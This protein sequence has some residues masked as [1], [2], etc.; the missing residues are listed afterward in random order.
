M[1]TAITI[2][3]PLPNVAQ[4]TCDFLR[5]KR[6]GE[7]SARDAARLADILRDEAALEL[8]AAFEG[9]SH[10]RMKAAAFPGVS[11]TGI[12]R[13]MNGDPSNPLSRLAAAFLLMRR[14]GI[15]R[16]RA[17]KLWLWL[18]EV[19]DQIW[20]PEEAEDEEGPHDPRA[21]LEAVR[22]IHAF[23]PRVIGTLRRL[24]AAEAIR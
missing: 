2:G 24:V 15:D 3:A 7:L 18:R 21:A 9:V 16:K 6:A 10:K 4:K 22:I 1:T 5:R 23:A 14:L 17:L 19:I 11:P 12:S 20:P 13:A 8:M